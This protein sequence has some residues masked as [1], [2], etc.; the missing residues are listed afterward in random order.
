MKFTEKK[1]E[2]IDRR[3]SAKLRENPIKDHVIGMGVS[4]HPEDTYTMVCCCDDRIVEVN[5]LS[6]LI[7]ELQMLKEAIEEETG[8]VL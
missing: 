5:S 7:E 4:L 6:R 2:E 1:L 8:L 3:F